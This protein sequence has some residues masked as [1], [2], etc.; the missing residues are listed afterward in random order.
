ME[1]KIILWVLGI[2]AAL[3]FGSYFVANQTRSETGQGEK[4]AL[5]VEKTSVD[6]GMMK[7][8]EQKSYDFMVKN[9]GNKPLQLSEIISS[10]GCTVGQV[11]YE[12]KTS[13]EFGMH[14]KSGSVFEVAPQKQATVRVIYRPY[15]MPVA[16]YVERE[17][18]VTTND[19]KNPKL[20]FKVTA[21]V[22]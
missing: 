3:V 17:V 7:V 20:T 15:V 4:S 6:L 12:G 5:S 21:V 19:P 18:Y 13:E 8:S 11:I 22:R 9:V 1:K 2:S 10:C 16:G 14:S